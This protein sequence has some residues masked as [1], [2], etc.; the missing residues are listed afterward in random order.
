MAFNHLSAAVA[1]YSVIQVLQNWAGSDERLNT[2]YGCYGTLL[3]NLD[4]AADLKL[5]FIKS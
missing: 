2:L 5:L 4:A 1:G 3:A